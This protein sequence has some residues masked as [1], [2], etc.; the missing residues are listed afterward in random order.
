MTRNW[1]YYQERNEPLWGPR[2]SLIKA[3]RKWGH[4]TQDNS[5]QVSEKW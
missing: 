4:N 5:Y 2:H 1:G 3:N